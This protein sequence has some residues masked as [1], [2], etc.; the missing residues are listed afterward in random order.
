MPDHAVRYWLLA[1]PTPTG[2]FSVAE[3]HAE[4]AA[5]RVTW[6]TPACVVGATAWQPLLRTPGVGPH[7]GTAPTALP[8]A[9]TGSTTPVPAPPPP[10][11]PAQPPS[12][13]TAPPPPSLGVKVAIIAFFAVGLFA[14]LG[15]GAY[16][17]YEAVR[18][19]TPTEV[20]EKL[21]DA[22][23]AAEAKKYATARLHAVLDATFA[24]KTPDDP[25]DTFELTGGEV[26]GPTPGTKRVGFRGSW[27]VPEAGER[28]RMEGYIAL[29]QSGGWKADDLVVTGVEG[30]ALSGPVSL[31]DEHRKSVVPPGRAGGGDFPLKRPSGPSLPT[32][33]AGPSAWEKSKIGGAFTGL[34]NAIGWGGVIV[35]AVLA[36]VV[37]GVREHLKHK[38]R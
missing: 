1:G 38:R 5:G 31:A 35:L 16:S 6:D 28:V 18:P 9:V 10:P 22:K 37:W 19:Y 29:I 21:G 30:A 32:K 8:P 24:D 25:N 17:L 4:L 15:W 12:A 33:P 3:V 2:P 34:K 7:A 27:F 20:C 13:T 14:L 23:T 26:D 36:A 11:T